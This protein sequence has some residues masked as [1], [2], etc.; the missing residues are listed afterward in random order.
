MRSLS[1]RRVPLSL[2]ACPYTSMPLPNSATESHLAGPI[3]ITS[4]CRNPDPRPLRRNQLPPER[5]TNPERTG[6]RPRATSTIARGLARRLK[7]RTSSL[8]GALTII[9]SCSCSCPP[10][11]SLSQRGS[12]FSSAIPCQSPSP[13]P[14]DRICLKASLSLCRKQG[15]CFE[16]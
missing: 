5:E 13:A 15:N 7:L 8:I 9:S 6:F 1:P 11:K 3:F 10:L 4:I 12:R 14:F 2:A 16:S